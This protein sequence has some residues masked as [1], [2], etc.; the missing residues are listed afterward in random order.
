MLTTD[1]YGEI[2][3]GSR[4][5]PEGKHTSVTETRPNMFC[6]CSPCFPFYPASCHYS[7]KCYKLAYNVYLNQETLEAQQNPCYGVNWTPPDLQH[8]FC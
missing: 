7:D 5:E 8:L 2:T 6:S 4:E 3:P 1:Y